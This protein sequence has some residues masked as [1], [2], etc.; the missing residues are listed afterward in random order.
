MLFLV[1]RLKYN[2]SRLYSNL[3]YEKLLFF[4][5]DLGGGRFCTV[6]PELFLPSSGLLKICSG[7]KSNKHT[8]FALSSKVGTINSN[9]DF[10]FFLCG[11][12]VVINCSLRFNTIQLQCV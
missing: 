2:N 12:Q 7:C 3:V 9:F 10:L 8:Y 11:K 5:P 1:T 4:P 6:D